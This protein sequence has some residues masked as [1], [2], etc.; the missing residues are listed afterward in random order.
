MLLKDLE[1]LLQMAT[2]TGCNKEK[3]V[4][5]S[6]YQEIVRMVEDEKGPRDVE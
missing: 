4:A 6:L 1:V 3:R 5:L 2:A